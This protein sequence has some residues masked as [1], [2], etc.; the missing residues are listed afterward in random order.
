MKRS[1]IKAA[2]VWAKELLRK[3]WTA[4]RHWHQWQDGH[5]GRHQPLKKD[6]LDLSI[7]ETTTQI[8]NNWYFR[9]FSA[10]G[11]LVHLAL[12]YQR[13]YN[14]SC[15]GERI[16]TVRNRPSTAIY[17]TSLVCQISQNPKA[18]DTPSYAPSKPPWI[19]RNDSQVSRHTLIPAD[20]FG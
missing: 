4:L 14:T 3:N 17:P 20:D 12:S 19:V 10:N 9:K 6:C 11:P 5:M 18:T 8:I 1:E 7:T 2:I 13:W 16:P 15:M